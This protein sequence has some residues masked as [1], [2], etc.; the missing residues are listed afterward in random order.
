MVN[1]LVVHSRGFFYLRR[2]TYFSVMQTTAKRS[3]FPWWLLVVPA[4]LLLY[5]GAAVVYNATRLNFFIAKLV[6][7]FQGLTPVLDIYIGV[8]NPTGGTFEIN[9]ITGNV[10]VDENFLGNLSSFTLIQ[11]KPNAQTVF[12]ATL[13]LSLI[14]VVQEVWNAIQTGLSTVSFTLKFNGTVNVNGVPVPAILSY[15]II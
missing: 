6:P 14:G 5:K 3:G 8:Q 9:S 13:R 11:I 4:G 2:F 1:P 12:V 15:K 7:R 10:Y